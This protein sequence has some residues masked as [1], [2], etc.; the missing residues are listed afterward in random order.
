[1]LDN[2]VEDI[3][4]RE[5]LAFN[6]GQVRYFTFDDTPLDRSTGQQDHDMKNRI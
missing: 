2:S 4:L 1:M 3:I 5:A 6:L